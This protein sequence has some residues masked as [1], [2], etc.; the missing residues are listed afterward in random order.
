M[1][2]IKIYSTPSILYTKYSPP[3]RVSC[4]SDLHPLYY[5]IEKY[6][7]ITRFILYTSNDPE[8]H[9]RLAKS[10]LL[11]LLKHT[12]E[13]HRKVVGHSS[14]LM[15]TRRVEDSSTGFFAWRALLGG[16]SCIWLAVSALLHLRSA[17]SSYF[18]QPWNAT[19]KDFL[20]WLMCK[21]HCCANCTH[22]EA[23]LLALLLP[24]V[25][26]H[27]EEGE[28]LSQVPQP[29]C[30]LTFQ[31]RRGPCLQNLLAGVLT[32]FSLVVH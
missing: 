26:P 25:L 10:V 5:S 3:S 23:A 14:P 24:R 18:K 11:N 27:G 28:H 15:H 19:K 17:S 29:T 21:R 13:K 1:F 4:H 16:P 6:P 30:L 8:M 20:N 12:E 31:V 9:R 22:M 7:G 2:Y 32:R